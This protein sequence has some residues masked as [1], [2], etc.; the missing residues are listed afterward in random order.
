M[1]GHNLPPLVEIGL[2]VL[3]GAMAPPGTTDLKYSAA[4]Q[5]IDR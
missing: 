4:V 1:G 3:G 5:Q 2:T